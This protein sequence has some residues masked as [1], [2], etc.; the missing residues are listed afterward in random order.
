MVVFELVSSDT[1]GSSNQRADHSEITS[2]S[3][4]HIFIF[5]IASGVLFFPKAA[6]FES[7]YKLWVVNAFLKLWGIN[8]FN[9]SQ[10]SD[11]HVRLNEGSHIVCQRIFRLHRHVVRFPEVDPTHQVFLIETRFGRASLGGA[12]RGPSRGKLMDSSGLYLHW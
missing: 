7:K 1:H 10:S 3:V 4:H 8:G 2:A 6:Y 5:A 12:H 11:C 9:M